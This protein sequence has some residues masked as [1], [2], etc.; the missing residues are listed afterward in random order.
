LSVK[1]NDGHP[2]DFP[3]FATFQ[4]LYVH[5]AAI[6]EPT[7]TDT[8][9]ASIFLA[10]TVDEDKRKFRQALHF[11]MQLRDVNHE[12]KIPRLCGVLKDKKRPPYKV[13]ALRKKEDATL[14]FVLTFRVVPAY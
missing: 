6:A 8:A 2:P 5:G 14:F 3:C 11:F 7:G 12:T 9:L 1:F 10:L 4:E 13:V